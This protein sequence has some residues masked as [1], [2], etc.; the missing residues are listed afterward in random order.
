[1]KA[2]RVLIKLGGAALDTD[3][4]LEVVSEAIQRY[5]QLGY[6]VILVH[7]GGPAIN[8]ELRQRGIT[9]NFVGGQR[10][11]TPAMI[12]VIETTLCG[13]VNRRLVRHFGAQGLPVVGLSGTDRQ[14]LL[15]SQ[16]SLELGLV[17]KIEKVNAEWIEEMLHL[18]QPLVP[19]IAPVGTSQSGQCYNINADWAATHLAVALQVDELVFLT[20]QFGVL[21][22]EG[23]LISELDSDGMHNM[24]ECKVVSG[25]MLTK[26]Q[27]VLFA[28]NNG[29]NGVRVLKAVDS[30]RAV[31]NPT[32]GT[33]C[34][35][36]G[37]ATPV[38]TE[39]KR[40]EEAYAAV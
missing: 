40:Q 35:L 7:G 17:G 4:T 24:I 18:P 36:A 38:T 16:A 27:A 10:V 21:D 22:E 25:G 12:E 19:V 32:L 33:R 29:V 6:K 13:G 39:R 11:T 31:T 30:N 26:I 28:L 14:T 15:C 37:D 1:M 3:L 20:D 2:P 9:W 8:N 5:R 34:A 23:E